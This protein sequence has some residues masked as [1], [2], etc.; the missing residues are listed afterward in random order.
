MEFDYKNYFTVEELK[1]RGYD[2]EA[3]GILD[4]EHFPSME[5]A[6]D[7]FMNDAFDTIYTLVENYRGA[8]WTEAFFTDMARDDLSGEALKFKQR[9]NKALIEQAIFIYDNGNT[10]ATFD[11]GRKAYAPKAVEAL[12]RNALNCGRG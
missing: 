1:Y 11:D 6:I 12:W 5:Y 4:T 10:K 9:L 8:E 2:L 3:D 7:D